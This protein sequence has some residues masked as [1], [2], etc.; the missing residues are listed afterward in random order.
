V[1]CQTCR[2]AANRRRLLRQSLPLDSA[3]RHQSGKDTRR[4]CRGK[5]GRAHTPKCFKYLESG[6]V[7]TGPGLDHSKT[8]AVHWRTL[9][10]T[11]CGK[12]LDYYWPW[13]AG[14]PPTPP[15]WVDC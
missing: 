4:W 7:P 9:V 2:T 14:R 8:D 3:P 11:T 6:K 5:E 15:P 1:T 13:L 10:C 12:T